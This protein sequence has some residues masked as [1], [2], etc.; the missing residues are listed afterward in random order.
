[1]DE[2]CRHRQLLSRPE[3][4]PE[5]RV[6]DRGKKRHAIES[7][8]R[9]DQPTGG[10]SHRLD[11]QD[12]RHQ[13]KAREMTL[14]DGVGGRN[15]CLSADLP[16][17]DFQLDDAVDQL[18]VLKTHGPRAYAPLAATSSSMRALSFLSTKY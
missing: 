11:Q 1:M 5:L 3:D 6:L 9:D 13:R 14:E 2:S 12:S 10:L 17:G 8:R 15:R 7:M 4:H 16:V 18:E